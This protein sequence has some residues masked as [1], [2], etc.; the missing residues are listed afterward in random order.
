MSGVPGPTRS[1][2]TPLAPR[3]WRRRLA[4]ASW[5][6]LAF[7]GL[8]AILIVGA[9][10]WVGLRSLRFAPPGT[11]R[12]I[13][14]PDGSSYRNQAEK[15]KKAKPTNA[16]DPAGGNVPG[17]PGAPGL[18]GA[19]GPGGFGPGGFNPG[20]GRPGGRPGGG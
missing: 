20:G 7:V 12:M 14:G 15:Y 1:P 3:S 10:L 4:D 18:P 17:A 2:K 19:P 13:S 11:I 16:N 8:P 9:A 5:R 6:D